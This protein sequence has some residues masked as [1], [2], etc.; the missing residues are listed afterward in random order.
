MRIIGIA[1]DGCHI[2]PC[3]LLPGFSVYTVPTSLARL[4]DQSLGPQGLVPVPHSWVRGAFWSPEQI[5]EPMELLMFGRLVGTV[6]LS[7]AWSSLSL[8]LVRCTNSGPHPNPVTQELWAAAQRTG[9]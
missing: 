1:R 7:V 2:G 6:V 5:K 3:P 9:L 8:G 4:T